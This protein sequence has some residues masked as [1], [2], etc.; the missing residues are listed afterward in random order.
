MFLLG[1]AEWF[2]RVHVG[3]C[4]NCGVLV[5]MDMLAMSPKPFPELVDLHH[6]H[7]F[8]HC[9]AQVHTVRRLVVFHGLFLFFSFLF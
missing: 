4:W 9:Q 2:N 8:L 1:V 7:H 5:L 6:F 3:C